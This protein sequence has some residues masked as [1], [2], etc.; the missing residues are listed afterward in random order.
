MKMKLFRQLH[1]NNI[2]PE[3]LSVDHFKKQHNR[4]KL[5]VSVLS[6]VIILSFI[7]GLMIIRSRN[8]KYTTTPGLLTVIAYAMDDGVVSEIK[9]EEGVELPR[10]AIWSSAISSVPGLPIKLQYP[11]E[12]VVFDISVDAGSFVGRDDTPLQP[13]EVYDSTKS[14]FEFFGQ[15]FTLLK[16]QNI[17]WQDLEWESYDNIS[18]YNGSFP[19]QPEKAYVEILIRK[20]EHIIG[21]TVIKI[22]MHSK[23]SLSYLAKILKSVSFPKI[24]GEY[25]KISYEYVRDKIDTIKA[26]S[27]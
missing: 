14:S 22:Y 17:Y 21:Y 19:V 3:P 24:N 6:V 12:D 13:N 2:L 1:T 27:R 15:K 18:S 5:F 25:Q 11:T 26:D 23:D 16:P 4:K 7:V 10:K 9:M 20:D 8:N